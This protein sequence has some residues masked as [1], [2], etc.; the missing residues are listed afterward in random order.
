[1]TDDQL[2]DLAG[3]LAEDTV[4]KTGDPATAAAV[5]YQASAAVMFA[6][7]PADQIAP[8][9][10]EIMEIAHADIEEALGKGATVQ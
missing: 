6:H 5:L 2:D 8:A 1:M 9:L 10:K 3:A 4:A 7:F